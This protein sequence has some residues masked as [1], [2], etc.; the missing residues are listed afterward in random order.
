[1]NCEQ[2]NGMLDRLMDDELTAAERNEL[3]AHAQSCPACGGQIR[4][5]M[6]MKALFD[7][8]PAEADVPLKAQAAWRGAVRKEAV[9]RRRGQWLRRFAAAAAAVVVLVGA[10]LALN[11]TAMRAPK[12]MEDAG[13]SPASTAMPMPTNEALVEADMAL[14]LS[15]SAVI[16]ADGQ[17]LPMLAMEESAEA[18]APMVELT[19][20]VE[21][22]DGACKLI[23]DAAQEYEGHADEQRL[24]QGGANLYVD[25]PA[26]NAAEFLS[27][28]AHLDA[29]GQS[30]PEFPEDS[31]GLTTLLLSV[32]PQ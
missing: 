12:T 15:E 28:I 27:A 8:I 2:I 20:S 21:D 1:M 6:Q 23:C 25:L 7:E 18:S 10:G 14:S 17:A 30:W 19:L 32:K 13:L 24:E 11:P 22:V 4:A 31:E 26:G 3:Q 5:T 29:S 9:Q 16:E